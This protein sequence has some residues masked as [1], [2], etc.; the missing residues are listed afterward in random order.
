[1]RQIVSLVKDSEVHYALVDDEDGSLIP[2]ADVLIPDPE[3]FGLHEA[4]VLGTNLV[5]ALRL[6]GAKRPKASTEL[7]ELPA[8]AASKPRETARERRNRLAREKYHQHKTGG[9]APKKS[10][11]TN[12]SQRYITLDEVLAVVNQHPEGIRVPDVVEIIWR[13]TD[14]Q[15]TDEPYPHWFY[16]SVMNRLNQARIKLR[17]KGV[18]LPFREESRPVPD[19]DGNHRGNTGMYLMP[20]AE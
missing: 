10:K 13:S 3:R 4:A 6:N 16:T 5:S 17:E 2:F 11:G 9:S 14:G 18:P 12:T 15:G 20:L 7:V 19:K 1:M 8:G